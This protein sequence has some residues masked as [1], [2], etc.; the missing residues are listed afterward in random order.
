MTASAVTKWWRVSVFHTTYYATSAV[1]LT[2]HSKYI[3]MCSVGYIFEHFSYFDFCFFI[4]FSLVKQL[5]SDGKYYIELTIAIN[6]PSLPVDI[7]KKR[8]EVRCDSETT[9]QTVRISQS[10]C[11]H[12]HIHTYTCIAHCVESEL[13]MHKCMNGCN[14]GLDSVLVMLQSILFHCLRWNMLLKPL[15]LQ[16]ASIWPWHMITDQTFLLQY[17]S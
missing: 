14:G 15:S 12:T 7:P 2:V 3:V 4:W 11:T 5:F 8:P 16:S 13:E 10:K 6:T 9:A 1:S 17:N